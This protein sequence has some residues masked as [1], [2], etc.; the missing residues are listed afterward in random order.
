MIFRH[1]LPYFLAARQGVRYEYISLIVCSLGHFQYGVA[2]KVYEND[3]V[4]EFSIK[5]NDD[6]NAQSGLASWHDKRFHKCVVTGEF[7]NSYTIGDL[8]PC[9]PFL[10][11][12]TKVSSVDLRKDRLKSP[13]LS[14]YSFGP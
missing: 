11:I 13:T 3:R 6:L 4:L 10:D 9:S 5:R 1:L 2:S 7:S 14:V 12:I 8:E